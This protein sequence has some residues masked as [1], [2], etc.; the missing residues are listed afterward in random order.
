MVSNVLEQHSEYNISVSVTGCQVN[1]LRSVLRIFGSFS[2]FGLF[3]FLS[4]QLCLAS[5][6]LATIPNADKLNRVCR[7]A[8]VRLTAELSKKK[9]DNVAVYFFKP[10][11]Y[12]LKDMDARTRTEAEIISQAMEDVLINRSEFKILN[13]N[14]EV[15]AAVLHEEDNR[16]TL[17]NNDILDV[18]TGFGAEWIVTG[19]Y[20]ASNDNC[21]HL[22]ARLF[23]CKTGVSLASALVSTQNRH[24]QPL[25]AGLV[26]ILI[27]IGGGGVLYTISTRKNKMYENET[28]K[29]KN[30]TPSKGIEVN[31]SANSKVS[32]KELL[33]ARSVNPKNYQIDS[34]NHNLTKPRTWGTFAICDESNNEIK[35]KYR[36]GNYPIRKME[37]EEEF[38][39]AELVAL[40]EKRGD[41]KAL[42]NMLKNG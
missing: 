12:K 13:R 23:N 19:E 31:S 30:S 34:V 14:S 7:E 29:I 4:V 9:L 24:L 1:C 40:F 41:A 8:A 2:L 28:L 21:F 33:I 18:G 11:G 26:A 27:L 10:R 3:L 17:N 25:F 38:G 39:S 5:V 16:G 36:F 42:A 15:W 37:L 22:R 20:W 6:A 35:N 32:P